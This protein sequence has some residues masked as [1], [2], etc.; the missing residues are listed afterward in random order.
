M[1]RR[2]PRAAAFM[3]Q[4]VA[5]PGV[6]MGLPVG[7][8]RLGERH[9]WSQGRP[10]A[11]NLVGVLPL[12]AGAALLA[13]AMSSHNQAAS[14]GWE[15]SLAPDYLLKGGPYRFSR[16]P[17]YVGEAAIWA[18]WAVLFGSVPVAGGLAVLIAV[19][20]GAVRLEEWILHNRWAGAYDAYR[21]RVPRW[22]KLPAVSRRK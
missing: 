21:D 1:R 4:A 6:F 3:V 18:G 15:I 5:L 16:N 17:M 2:L 14:E 19:Q 7:M 11:A 12:G 9:G 20:A 10:G 22:I 13:W 8:S